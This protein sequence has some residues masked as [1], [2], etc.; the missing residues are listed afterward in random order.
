MITVIIFPK[1]IIWVWEIT[2]KT[3][4]K[5]DAI[6]IL[7]TQQVSE[8]DP[9]PLQWGGGRDSVPCS[10]QVNKVQQ[11]FLLEAEWEVLFS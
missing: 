8:N 10:N 11:L 7:C 6:T 9:Q 4:S 5:T 1:N 3:G 2:F